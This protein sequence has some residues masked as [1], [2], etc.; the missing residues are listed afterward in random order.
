MSKTSLSHLLASV[1][2]WVS[3]T[4]VRHHRRRSDAG[5]EK[6]SVVDAMQGSL[7]VRCSMNLGPYPIVPLHIEISS[8]NS[9]HTLEYERP[10]EFGRKL[11]DT[12]V[13]RGP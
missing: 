11:L 1:F 6:A 4:F 13:I 9:A 10:T 7:L 2:R 12:L 8:R 5:R 3:Y